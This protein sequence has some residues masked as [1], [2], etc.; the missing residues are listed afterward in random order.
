MR[1]RS[2]DRYEITINHP[3]YIDMPPLIVRRQEIKA[4]V[5]EIIESTG[6]KPGC[7]VVEPFIRRDS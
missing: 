6:I 1:M 3:R 7:V 5:G 2:I 4:I